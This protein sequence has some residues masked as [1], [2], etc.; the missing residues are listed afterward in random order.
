M[1][2]NNNLPMGTSSFDGYQAGVNRWD[3]SYTAGMKVLTHELGKQ[4]E[5]QKARMDA[6]DASRTT[7]CSY[8]PAYRNQAGNARVIAPRVP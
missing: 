2:D 6:E 4:Y 7:P 8:T 1:E 5:A 3:D